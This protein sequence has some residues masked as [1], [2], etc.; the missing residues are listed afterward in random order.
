MYKVELKNGFFWVSGDN[1]E[2]Q[3]FQWL[4]Y[5]DRKDA[6]YFLANPCTRKY[7]A[8]DMLGDP[9]MSISDADLEYLKN[10]R[11]SGF[12]GKYTKDL[13]LPALP[14][15]RKFKDY[16]VE[17][18]Y[19]MLEHKNYCMFLGPGTGKTLI[20][21]TYLNNAKPKNVLVLTPQK[22][23]NQYVNEIGKYISYMPSIEVTNFEQILAREEH[24]TSQHYDCMIIDESHRLKDYTGKTATIVRKKMDVDRMYLFSGTPQDSSRFD[25]MSQLALFDSRFVPSKSLFINRY[26]ELNDYYK[27]VKEKMPEELTEMIKLVSC[28]SETEDLVALTAQ[29]EFEIKCKKPPEYEELRKTKLLIRDNFELV[30]DTPGKLS[31]KLRELSNGF[32]VDDFGRKLKVESNKAEELE[33]LISNNIENG[34]IYTMF[35]EDVETV[36]PILEKNNRT[37]CVV[38]GKTKKP[39]ADKNIEDFKAGLC[40]FIVIQ[41]N[42]GKEGLDLI[43][44]NNTIF[45]SL[46]PSYITYKQCMHRTRR[47]G[48]TKDCNFYYLLCPGVDTHIRS[49]LLQKKSFNARLYRIYKVDPKE[50]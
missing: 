28:G 50:S 5:N 42:S 21:I 24:F 23:V 14:A 3:K 37:F 35:D 4:T 43:N 15:N 26:F 17:C 39:V 1:T 48:Q 41:A 32:C 47:L 6:Y 16:Q 11:M 2:I 45:F 29:N 40:E 25:V 9:N 19:K 10:F 44:T 33:K 7:F 13:E 36:V 38:T 27:P 30:C 31:I 20:A 18:V 46:P 49:L 34:I 12:I 22:V 8:R